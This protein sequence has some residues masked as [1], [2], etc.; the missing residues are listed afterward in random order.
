MRYILI[1][2]LLPVSFLVAAQPASDT[3]RPGNL[4]MKYLPRGKQSYLVYILAKDGY[5]KSPAA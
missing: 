1:L 4:D 5:K 2:L 3:I